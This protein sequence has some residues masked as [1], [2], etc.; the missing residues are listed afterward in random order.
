[1]TDKEQQDRIEQYLRNTMGDDEREEFETELKSDPYLKK[2]TESKQILIRGIKTGFNSELKSKLKEEDRGRTQIL[3]TRRIQLFSGI[4]AVIIIG[5]FSQVFLS[6]VKQDSGRIYS[7]YYKP[8]PNIN[9]PISRSEENGDSPYYQYETG[10]F[11]EALSGFITLIKENPA[12]DA[13][14]FY[15]GIANMELLDFEEAIIYLKRVTLDDQGI[16]TRPALWY[17]SLAYIYSDNYELAFD[18]LDKLAEG[19]DNYAI[20]SKRILK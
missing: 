13:A 1:M 18:Y 17:L 10:N 16:F 3:K 5:L 4:A 6:R 19:D 8:Y 14:V 7:E 11:R 12:D 15:A 20:N 2:L 9:I